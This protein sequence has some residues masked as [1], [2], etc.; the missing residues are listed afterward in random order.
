METLIKIRK[1]FQENRRIWLRSGGVGITLE[2]SL[3]RCIGEVIE[4]YCWY[5]NGVYHVNDLVFGNYN[6]VVKDYEVIDFNKI[7]L[8]SD[9]QYRNPKFPFEKFTKNTKIYW[10]PMYDIINKKEILYPAQL[11][12]PIYPGMEKETI[13]GYSTTSGISAHMSFK[14]SIETSL[15]EQI[16]RDAFLLTWYGK[17]KVP[18]LVFSEDDW[19]RMFKFDMNSFPLYNLNVFDITQ[20]DFKIP[21]FLSIINT[22]SKWPRMRTLIGVASHFNLENAIYKSILESF[23]GI[24]FAKRSYL[25]LNSDQ[26]KINIKDIMDFDRNFIFYLKYKKNIFDF[27]IN[28][29]SR[30]YLKDL[31]KK[32]KSDFKKCIKKIRNKKWYLLTLDLTL[33][34]ISE[35]GF[36]VT[37]TLIP[38]LIQLSIP[39]FPFLAHPRYK[40]IKIK[41]SLPHPLP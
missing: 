8:F 35:I 22:K 32:R 1:V 34:E 14:Q 13:I 20:K 3:W 6:N 27:L 39:S 26:N 30:V 10:I 2:E 9:F 41:N 16:E 15:L 29:S 37:K 18:R 11:V 12:L 38:E 23:Q 25:L 24:S 21:T 36:Y 4:R 5:L 40:N 33:P 28:S 19:K 17:I 31:L 7:Y